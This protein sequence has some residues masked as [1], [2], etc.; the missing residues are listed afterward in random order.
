M[1]TRGSNP[2]SVSLRRG[3]AVVEFAVAGLLLL[4]GVGG[5]LT[6]GSRVGGDGILTGIAD[7]MNVPCLLSGVGLAVAAYTA[8]RGERRWWAWQAALPAWWTV[9]IV[10]LISLIRSSD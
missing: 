8:W 4:L 7:A 1:E 6:S 9:A 10:V 3:L 2:A 5:V